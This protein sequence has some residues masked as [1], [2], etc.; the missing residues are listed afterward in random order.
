MGDLVRPAGATSDKRQGC[1]P[2]GMKQP[3]PLA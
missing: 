3:Q 2:N 1:L